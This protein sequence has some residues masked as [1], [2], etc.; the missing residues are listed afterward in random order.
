[1]YIR[2]SFHYFMEDVTTKKLIQSEG[3]AFFKLSRLYPV[4]HM[5]QILK[6]KFRGKGKLSYDT[7]L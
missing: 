6:S 4:L 7:A 2:K 3:S 5:Q 1:M